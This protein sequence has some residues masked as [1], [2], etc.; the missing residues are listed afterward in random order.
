MERWP[1]VTFGIR[2][3]LRVK[4]RLNA[5]DVKPATRRVVRRAVDAAIDCVVAESSSDGLDALAETLSDCGRTCKNKIAASLLEAMAQVVKATYEDRFEDHIKKALK[6]VKAVAQDF[7]EPSDRIAAIEQDERWLF[8]SESVAMPPARVIKNLESRPKL[9][10]RY[11]EDSVN[12]D[13][14]SATR[15]DARPSDTVVQAITVVSICIVVI[16]AII[17][18]VA[19]GDTAAILLGCGILGVVALFLLIRYWIAVAR[20]RATVVSRLCGALTT[21]GNMV[22]AAGLGGFRNL[23][24]DLV[25]PPWIHPGPPD[26]ALVLIGFVPTLFAVALATL[27]Y[28]RPE[29]VRV[30]VFGGVVA[31]AL[32]A[33]FFGVALWDDD[34]PT[35]DGRANGPSRD[36]TLADL[37]ALSGQDLTKAIEKLVQRKVNLQD[38][39]F[40]GKTLIGLQAPEGLFE[41]ASFAGSNIKESDFSGARLIRARFERGKNRKKVYAKSA[42][43]LDAELAGAVFT[44][45]L[46]FM[47]DFSGAK[48]NN[49]FF[50]GACCKDALFQSAKIKLTCFK[51]AD[52]TGADFR[53]SAALGKRQE[54]TTLTDCDFTD[55]ILRDT[56]FQGASVFKINLKNAC[57][58]GANFSGTRV[59]SADAISAC[60]WD[61]TTRLDGLPADQPCQKPRSTACSTK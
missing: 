41:G 4:A 5:K 8:A 15:G 37:R 17:A 57:L 29:R 19:T 28:A 26:I 6:A 3:F 50:D 27:M 16:A 1:S 45:A 14:S 18:S 2:S 10:Q 22:C 13:A 61:G 52:L 21:T 44:D 33:L 9:E 7:A 55:A 36:G 47:A 58:I 32:A 23:K 24:V 60:C 38:Q 12:N 54:E 20:A 34:P 48:M 51:G 46:L 35:E 43:F 56:K 42:K 53:V 40:N 25:T 31:C 39:E 30:R 59:T 49:S 11:S